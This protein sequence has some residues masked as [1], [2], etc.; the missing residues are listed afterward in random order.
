MTWLA[1]SRVA[2][3]IGRTYDIDDL[4]KTYYRLYRSILR[5]DRW[6]LRIRSIMNSELNE[7]APSAQEER[8]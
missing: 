6:I 1:F 4:A 3:A 5:E 7:P 8:G 2:L